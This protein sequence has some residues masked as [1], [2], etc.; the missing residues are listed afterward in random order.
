MPAAPAVPADRPGRVHRFPRSLRHPAA[1]AA[2]HGRLRR[3]FRREPH[4]DR[5]DG[6]GSAG[7]TG[8]RPRRRPDRPQAG[9]RALGLRAGCCDR[10]GRY[11]RASRSSCSGGSCRA[12]RRPACSPRRSLTST[13]SGRPCVGRTTAAYISGTV[14]GGFSG[15]ALVGI[16]AAQWTWQTAFMTL[17]RQP[18]G[19]IRI[20]CLPAARAASRRRR[21]RNHGQSIARL[22]RNRQLIATDA[23]G[24]CVLFTQVA[25]FTYVTFT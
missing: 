13:T 9:D 10:G 8:G 16:V 18:R 21:S 17:A 15:R 1:A 6:C 7:G 19:G 23:V 20:G 5:C 24:L 14:T 3:P 12:W 22:L 4:R 25:M 11:L 2:P